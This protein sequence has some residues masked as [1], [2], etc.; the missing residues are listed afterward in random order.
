MERKILLDA[1]VKYRES[2]LE[3]YDMA[4]SMN[5]IMAACKEGMGDLLERFAAIEKD[6]LH[7]E[8]LRDEMSTARQPNAPQPLALEPVITILR[9]K[10][11]SYEDA[12]TVARQKFRCVNQKRSRVEK[13]RE[14]RRKQRRAKRQ[15]KAQR[16]HEERLVQNQRNHQDMMERYEVQGVPSDEDDSDDSD[17]VD[18]AY[19]YVTNTSDSTYQY[20]M[21]NND[22]SSSSYIYYK[23]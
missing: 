10:L 2:V 7:I 4:V 11:K 6:L 8:G 3:M 19:G 18:T 5:N 22:T 17:E 21:S 20:N 1:F 16:A 23:Y 9:D 15:A 12:L 13:K 14:R